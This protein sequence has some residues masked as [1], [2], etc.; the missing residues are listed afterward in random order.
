MFFKYSEGATP[1]DEDERQALIPLHIITQDQLNEFEHYN[2]S[3]CLPWAYRQKDIL[4]VSF[5]KRLHK[6]MFDHTWKWAGL[7]R[8]TQKNIEV[9]ALFIEQELYAL[10]KNTLYQIENNVFNADEIAVRFHHRL[11]WIHAFPNGN[12]RHAR[13]MTDLLVKQLRKKPFT[14][15]SL[16]YDHVDIVR[17]AYIKALRSADQHD[18]SLLMEFVHS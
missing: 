3:L 1:I 4:H 17:K 18:F 16:N 2:I 10:C 13:L 6:R 8:R 5:M 12:G 7:F 14:W 9:D 15:G 11:V